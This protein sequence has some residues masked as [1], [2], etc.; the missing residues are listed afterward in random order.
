MILF[1]TGAFHHSITWGFLV[2]LFIVFVSLLLYTIKEE[3]L[4]LWRM[5]TI[6]QKYKRG[7][8][9]LSKDRE[10]EPLYSYSK[11]EESSSLDSYGEEEE[12][13]QIAVKELFS[14]RMN[15]QYTAHFSRISA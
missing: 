3:S 14:S 10:R 5:Y 9:Y 13:S 4:I 6:F 8:K 1:F 2:P 7:N 11:N 15:L 12:K